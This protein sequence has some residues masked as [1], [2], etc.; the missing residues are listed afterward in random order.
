MKL[1]GKIMMTFLLGIMLS[2]PAFSQTLNL[3]SPPNLST[4]ND[5]SIV[6]DWG[7]VANVRAY[8]L[9]ISTSADMS[10]PIF[11]G[12]TGD[13]SSYLF[14]IPLHDQ[15]YYWQVIADMNEMP[16]RQITS[17]TW[18]F[19]TVKSPP[20]HVQPVAGNS[21]VTKTYT[22]K[23]RKI[24]NAT[25]NF[26]L[27]AVRTFNS[28]I[29]N[30]M[31]LTDTTVVITLPEYNQKYFWRVM[32]EYDG[33][34]TM[35]S[36]PDSFT[37]QRQ[38]VSLV[39]PANNISSVSK[40]NG[41]RLSWSATVA[42]SNYTMQVSSDSVFSNILSEY[43]GSSTSDSVY[44]LNYNMDYYWR[45]RADYSGCYTEWSAFRHFRTEYDKPKN[46]IPR[47]DSVCVPLVARLRWDPVDGAVTY[48]V[49]I[50]E[51]DDF[52][53]TILDSA[54]INIY[55]MNVVFPKTEQLYY[56]R[57]KAQDAGNSSDW[58]PTTWLRT[59]VG[60]PTRL[61]PADGSPKL[62]QTVLFKW[63]K[64]NPYSYDRIQI[65]NDSSFATVQRDI[66]AIAADSIILKMAD[67]FATYYWRIQ[68]DLNLCV[69]A[70]SSTWSFSTVLLPPVLTYPENDA[71]GQ[72][73][74]FTFEWKASEG[75]LTYD[76]NLSTDPNFGNIILGRTGLPSTKIFYS[77]MTADTKY[78]WR[79]RAVNA[80]G[81]S[82]W[83]ATFNFRTAT[84][85]LDVPVQITPLPGED[86]I[87]VNKVFLIWHSVVDATKYAV[88]I[89]ENEDMSRPIINLIDHPDTTYPFTG[90]NY[91]TTYFWRIM[92]MNATTSSSWSTVWGFSTVVQAPTEA[93]VLIK[94]DDKLN[95]SPTEMTF[96]WQDVARA[97]NYEFELARDEDFTNIYHRDTNVF[98]SYAYI[99]NIE[100]EKTFYWR[101][102]AKNYS[103]KGPWSETRSLTTLINSVDEELARKF[104]AAINPNPV[105]G[106]AYLSLVAPADNNIRIVL[107]NSAGA[108]LTTV[109]DGAYAAGLNSFMIKSDILDNG[110]YFAVIEIGNHSFA[111]KFV[112][113]K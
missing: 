61:L 41:L 64:S 15:T 86:R 84:Q 56:W 79:V 59:A 33:C 11:D 77:N 50:S 98:T 110:V 42:P 21:C 103:G 58:S 29:E 91:G 112:V 43:I 2:I 49:Q 85:P 9:R 45:V 73:L 99:S 90:M 102:R 39:S 57:V 36:V 109:A 71:T 40:I 60:Y 95:P 34:I 46:L 92:A 20:K 62:A 101:V 47:E 8:I 89:S 72:S 18:S 44:N 48:R 63:I 65:S 67:Q 55:Y 87:P 108:K 31:N 81:T 3:I 14:Q 97:E 52:S 35:F 96:D 27:S 75:A 100:F 32:A 1:T 28:L 107:F 16:P 22:F 13:T 4:C 19:R 17:S 69:S 106:I 113:N 94:P 26:Q 78:Y 38:P 68:S 37:T 111:M 6:F 5:T 30:R 10:N 7:D 83:S 93:P 23:W 104:S 12:V 70:W 105:N 51:V 25:Y 82:D 54:N 53:T 76:F 66:K 74:A 24:T 80:R 88:Q